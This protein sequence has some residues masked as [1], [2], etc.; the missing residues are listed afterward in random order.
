MKHDLIDASD[1]MTI[2]AAAV[3]YERNGREKGE[4]AAYCA[5]ETNLQWYVS[6]EC[7]GKEHL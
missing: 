2:H 5:V 7:S 1:S 4:S 6:D 3:A